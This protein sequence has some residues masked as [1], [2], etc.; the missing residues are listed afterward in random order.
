MASGASTLTP[1]EPETK[2][3]EAFRAGCENYGN[4][5]RLDAD[6]PYRRIWECKLADEYVIVLGDNRARSFDS[7]KMGPVHINQVVAQAVFTFYPFSN[8]G[9]I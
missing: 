7:R 5:I 8:F 3:V 2:H 1:F 9:T 6:N 4:L